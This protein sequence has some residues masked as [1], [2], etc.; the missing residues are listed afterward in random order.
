[1]SCDIIQVTVISGA[2][3][4]TSVVD[5]GF[6]GTH[7]GMLGLQGGASGEYY[8][9]SSNQYSAL[10]G[11][12]NLTGTST[13]SGLLELTVSDLNLLSVP[14]GSAISYEGEISAF[15][16]TNLKAAA[17][18]YKCLLANKTG[19][20]EKIGFSQVYGIAD[21]SSGSW[22][23]YVNQNTG[24]NYF[25]IQVKGENSATIKWNASVEATSVS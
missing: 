22:Q 11:S 6:G 5:V 7:N 25:Q 19:T 20:V 9:L 24:I 13:T 3:G 21:D 14:T 1:M 16:Q 8:H 10:S 2:Q 12:F 23:I 18:H 17:W 15:D 4:P